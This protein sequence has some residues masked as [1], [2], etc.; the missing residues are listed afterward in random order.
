MV[1]LEP[2]FNLVDISATGLAFL[3]ERPFP[4]GERLAIIVRGVVTF[5][6]RVLN[7]PMV[8]V[9]ANLME[10]RYRVQCAFSNEMDGKQLVLLLKEYERSGNGA[11]AASS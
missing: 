2:D 9:D 5:Q 8:E 11:K 3:S 1:R 4:V 10:L 6:V 7:C